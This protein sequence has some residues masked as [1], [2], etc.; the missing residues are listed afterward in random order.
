MA[1]FDPAR[2]GGLTHGGTFNNNA[3]TMAAGA[4]IGEALIDEAALAAVNERG[5]RLRDGLQARLDGIGWCVTGWGSILN[6]HPVPGPVTSPDDLADADQRW[7]ELFFH[8]MLAA[9]FYLAPR[10]YMAL[11]M[12]V[13]DDDTGRFLAAVENFC[14]P[15]DRALRR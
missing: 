5:D 2:G 3:F 9:G 1:A 8:D 11:S 10:G 15:D 12:D 7:R 13:S 4:A 6:V 14:R